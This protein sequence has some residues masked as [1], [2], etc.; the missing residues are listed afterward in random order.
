MLRLAIHVEGQTERSFVSELLAPYFLQFNIFV[1]PIIICTSK[2]HCG[3]KHLGGLTRKSY[4]N[5]VRKELI[6][7]LNSF[8]FVTTLYDYYGIP[9]DFPGFDSQEKNADKQI[10]NICKALEKDL[11]KKNFFPFLIKHEFES[12]LFTKPES[13][14]LIDEDL[15]LEMKKI[16][17]EFN[18]QPEM[19]NNNKNTSPS[20]RIIAT[21]PSYKKVL[22]GNLIAK[23]IALDNMLNM[24]PH[25]SSWIEKIKDLANQIT[26]L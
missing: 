23:D 6:R 1:Q 22:H 8:D 12:L 18:N 20:H 16:L 26:Y 25:F 21:F 13:A 4:N 3:K 15:A 17:M 14:S 7:L 5:N 19:I 11:N 2:D 9:S 10:D 24:C